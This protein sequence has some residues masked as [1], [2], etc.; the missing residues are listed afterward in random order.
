MG[1]R[2]GW[3]TCKHHSVV[4]FMRPINLFIHFMHMCCENSDR[5]HGDYLNDRNCHSYRPF[6]KQL[7]FVIYTKNVSVFSQTESKC[8]AKLICTIQLY[9]CVQRYTV[10]KIVVKTC[11]ENPYGWCEHPTSV[12]WP[13]IRMNCCFYS[14]R[15]QKTVI[16]ELVCISPALGEAIIFCY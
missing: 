5:D 10:L 7:N 13:S 12:F 8:D 9:N 11:I 6:E 4:C 14:F 15:Y 1:D 3:I 2:W 16:Y